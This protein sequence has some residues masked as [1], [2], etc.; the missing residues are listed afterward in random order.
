MAIATTYGQI[1]TSG[2]SSLSEGVVGLGQ[3][4]VGVGTPLSGGLIA[5]PLADGAVVET[6]W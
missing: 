3:A 6:A 2:V 4:D 1:L 5:S